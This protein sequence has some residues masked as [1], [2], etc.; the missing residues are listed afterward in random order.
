MDVP[1]G[2]WS[3]V[4]G[5]GTR[6]DT[7]ALRERSSLRVTKAYY[8][9]STMLSDHHYPLLL[10]VH[11][12]A[13][14]VNKPGAGYNP[15]M[16][17]SHMLPVRLPADQRHSYASEVYSR[18]RGDPVSDSR[19][20]I[21]RLQLAIYEW[22]DDRNKVKDR[23]FDGL[24]LEERPEEET[25]DEIGELPMEEPTEMLPAVPDFPASLR[26]EINDA[27]ATEKDIKAKMK[28]LTAQVN[29]EVEVEV[30]KGKKRAR[31]EGDS[32]GRTADARGYVKRSLRLNQPEWK[33]SCLMGK[34]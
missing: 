16:T 10:V 22:A 19:G 28:L 21:K 27:H 2:V 24:T 20:F 15:R 7:A 18:D 1:E 5:Q 17:E 25:K 14:R 31:L 13:I 34:F 26:K 30:A 33:M 23:Q 12:P 11:V 3:C 6:I 32:L 29:K 8:W 4:A 9:P